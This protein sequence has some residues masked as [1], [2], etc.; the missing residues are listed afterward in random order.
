[1]TSIGSHALNLEREGLSLPDSWKSAPNMGKVKHDESKKG[2]QRKGRIG[3]GV[4]SF[5]LG[6]SR[7]EEKKCN[8][9]GDLARESNRIG[10]GRGC[11]RNGYP[12]GLFYLLYFI[13]RFDIPPFVIT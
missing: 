6:G 13:V 4:R 3:L 7:G 1:M 9:G 11:Y 8:G 2:A 12:T 10:E 5:K